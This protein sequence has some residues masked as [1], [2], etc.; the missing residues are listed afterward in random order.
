MTFFKLFMIVFLKIYV[1]GKMF[2]KI[3]LI[4]LFFQYVVCDQGREGELGVISNRKGKF[5]LLVLQGVPPTP[6]LSLS[7]TSYSLHEENSGEYLVFLLND[8]EKS[9]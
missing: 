4:Y 5:N 7:V 9:E 2:R 3:C 6:I 1:T 8:F